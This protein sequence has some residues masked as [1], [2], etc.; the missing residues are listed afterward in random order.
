MWKSTIKKT[1]LY[2]NLFTT[3][4]Q[5]TLDNRL[6]SKKG[7]VSG[8]VGSFYLF[9]IQHILRISKAHFNCKKLMMKHLSTIETSNAAEL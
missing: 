2:S 7:T 1:Y 9:A 8:L 3:F 5:Q 4:T 6:T